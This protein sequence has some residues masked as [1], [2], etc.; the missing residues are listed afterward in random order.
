MTPEE[1]E[2]RLRS[3]QTPLPPERLRERCLKARTRSLGP[4]ALA[5]AASFFVVALSAWLI[6]GWLRRNRSAAADELPRR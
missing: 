5:V 2:S 4:R 6:A 1:I 3:L